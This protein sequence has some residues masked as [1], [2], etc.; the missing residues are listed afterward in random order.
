M[1]FYRVTLE[2][3]NWEDRIVEADNEEEALSIAQ[4][5]QNNECEYGNQCMTAVNAELVYED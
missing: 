3:R 2:N 5:A 4:I 1:A